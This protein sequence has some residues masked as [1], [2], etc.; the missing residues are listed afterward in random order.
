MKSIGLLGG[1]FDPPHKGHLYISLEA[2]KILKLDEIWW[3][4]TPQNPL[5]IN[6]PASYSERVKN[7]NTFIKNKPIKIKEI[8]KKINSQYSY[9]TIKY[10]N[11]HYKN[12]KFFWLMGADNLINF[13]NWQN[14]NKIFDEIPIVVFRRYGYN[15]Q[16][17]KSYISN[18]YKNFR[19]KSKNIHINNFNQL[20]A[21]TVIQNKEIRISSTE[22]REQ[23]ELLR[24]KD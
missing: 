15:Q 19:I 16:A 23:R 18:L 20:P 17:L 22:I 11:N 14:A 6:K 2:K 10:L 12:I 5:K 24:P 4:V 8:E 7:C 21:W 9:Q 1:S 13:H 3:L